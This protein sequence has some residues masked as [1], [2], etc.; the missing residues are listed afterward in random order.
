MVRAELD[1]DDPSR[2]IVETRYAHRDL[3]KSVPSAKWDSRLSRWHVS[4]TW[5]SCVALRETFQAELE[6][7]PQLNDWAAK[8]LASVWSPAMSLR[9]ATTAPGDAD[10]FPHQRA[11]VKWMSTVR[12]GILASHM[13]VGK[14]PATIRTLVELT[15]QGEDVFPILIV[16][17]NSM[18]FT[19]K[20]EIEKWWPGITAQVITGTATQRRKQFAKPAHAF[21]MNYEALRSHS[22]LAPYGSIALT[23]CIECGGE[24]AKVTAAR[25]QVHIRE[26]NKI[27]FRTIIADEAHRAKDPKSQQTRALKAA[28]ADA[29]FRYALTGTPIANSVLDLWSILN[30]VDPVEWPS[31]TRWTDRLVDLIYNAFGG[32]AV[33][34]IK[35]ERREEFDRTINYRM[36]RMTKDVVLPFLPPIMPE[37]R[38][39]DMTPQQR[40]AYDTL[41]DNF[42][43]ELDSGDELTAIDPMTKMMR[44]LQLASSYGTVET[45][46]REDGKVSERLVLTAPSNK[47]DAFMGDLDDYMGSPTIVFAVSRQLIMLLSDAM[48][49][50]KIAH[51]LITGGQTPFERQCAIDDFQEGKTQFI[52]ATV[53]AGGTGVTLT[54]ADTVV[55]LQRSWSL[56]EMDQSIA[57]AHRIGSEIHDS[58][59]K[60]DY[61]TTDSV[62]EIVIKALEGKG[63]G[64]EDLVRDRDLLRKVLER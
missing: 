34:G 6:I 44:L 56:I 31:K 52:L 61:V 47:V 27:P 51:G 15:R 5:S 8:F 23:R 11:D 62:E 10:L 48:T 60:V 28:A 54:A 9:D 7:G 58:I 19:W 38:D 57:R 49:K 45:T 42:I 22:R 39:V 2:I 26:L 24:D 36:R 30:L 12:R 50:K 53:G 59:T 40:R 13:G 1:P 18:K 29:P 3:I 25:C 43:V 64:L 46:E 21:I 14:T 17:P 37:R 4:T 63:E 41:V 20:R 33:A 55:Y 35:A 16:A 32:V